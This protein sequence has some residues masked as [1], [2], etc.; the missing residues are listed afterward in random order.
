MKK[1]YL[2][3]AVISLFCISSC[4]NNKKEKL[5]DINYSSCEL[6][7]FKGLDFNYLNKNKKKYSEAKDLSKIELT[8]K[9]ELENNEKEV[10]VY[11][12][13]NDV[14]YKGEY[15]YLKIGGDYRG[16]PYSND[17]IKYEPYYSF[18]KFDNEYKYSNLIGYYTDSSF[19]KII[20][21][22]EIANVS[23]SLDEIH[24]RTASKE[25]TNKYILN[26]EYTF[27]YNDKTITAVV[28]RSNLS[29]ELNKKQYSISINLHYQSVDYLT[30]EEDDFIKMVSNSYSYLKQN[31]AKYTNDF[32]SMYQSFKLRIQYE[33]DN[34][35]LE[36]VTLT[37][38][39]PYSCFAYL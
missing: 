28:K 8:N 23:D 22:N 36:E 14:P 32:I 27:K 21:E 35:F 34:T 4:S 25:L 15:Q 2:L 29:F 31:I 16:Y 6:S 39:K 18:D 20:P 38:V 1:L 7:D 11:Y 19:A 13:Y 3:L 5:E 24:V 26:G 9:R 17:E 30:C 10:K 12:Y 37:N 33:L